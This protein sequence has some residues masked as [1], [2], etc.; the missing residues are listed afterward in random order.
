MSKIA[1][2]YKSRTMNIP[3][4]SISVPSVWGLACDFG[5]SS[6]KGI[7]PNNVFRHP[8]Y[9]KK[10]DNI[11]TLV[12]P[13]ITDIYY[14][15]CETGEMWAVGEGAQAMISME[16]TSDSE[17]ALYGRNR[18]YDPMFK[19]IARTGIG[20][21]LLN[22][23]YGSPSNKP[24]VLQTGLP[25]RYMKADKELL[26]DVLS[27]H[28]EYELKIGTSPWQK[29][30]FDLPVDNILVMP[31]PMGTL[32][33]ICKDNKGELIPEAKEYLRSSMLIFDP[34]FGTF[35]V[36]DIRGKQI[37]GFETFD[38]LGMK[39]VFQETV[40]EIYNQYGTEITV[41]ALQKY[42]ETGMIPVFERKNNKSYDKDFSDILLNCSQAVCK[43]AIQRINTLYNN[44]NDHRYLVITGG[45]GAAW[46]QIIRS[47]YANRKTLEIIPGNK[48]DDL[49]YVFS[50]VRGYY[51]TLYGTL[52]NSV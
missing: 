33:S 14:K 31:Q 20:F 3:R 32:L 25:P 26:Q 6:V 12:D 27:G 42:L 24:L 1:K 4:E 28:H 16:D 40:N 5:Y 21:G 41:P 52:K 44:L 38:D 15:D 2:N 30:S 49:S 17:Q 51:M 39:R 29:F 43:E 18:Y 13:D 11:I 46:D 8:S 7:S 47:E 19:V 22:N 37:K 9:A 50:N 48:N 10:V 34:G 36:F 45:T 35:D 23:Q